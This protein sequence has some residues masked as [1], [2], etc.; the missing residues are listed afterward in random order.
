[1]RVRGNKREVWKG[2]AMKTASGLTKSDLVLNKRNKVV[3]KKQHERG[4][5]NSERLRKH[6]FKK[7]NAKNAD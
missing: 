1:M 3:S 6:Q 4:K 2:S 7:K 5:Q